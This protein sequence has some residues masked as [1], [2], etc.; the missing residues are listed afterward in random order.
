MKRY[1]V[2]IVAVSTALPT[3]AP[4]VPVFADEEDETVTADGGIGGEDNEKAEMADDKSSATDES[5]KANEADES[6][7]DETD[8][9][10]DET[11]G[12][13]ETSKNDKA[14]KDNENDILADAGLEDNEQHKS[15]QPDEIVKEEGI[16]EDAKLEDGAEEKE[17]LIDNLD[18]P[19]KA[20]T[21]YPK[22]GSAEYVAWLVEASEEDIKAW[23]D[24]AVLYLNADKAT[25]SNAEKADKNILSFD[26]DAFWAWVYED[27]AEMKDGEW[28][29][30]MDAI[31]SWMVDAGYKDARAF[32][33]EFFMSSDILLSLAEYPEFGTTE[34]FAWL[35]EANEDQV[36]RWYEINKKGEEG[37]TKDQLAS[38]A[39]EFDSDAFWEW[40]QENCATMIDEEKGIFS[41]KYD[42]IYDWA[43]HVPFKT[44]YQFLQFLM[45]N[46]QT[47]TFASIGRLWPNNYG[48]TGDLYS[49]GRGTKENPYIIDS[50][51]DLRLLAATIAQNPSKY[52]NND[53]Y[54]LIENGT[55]DLNGSWIPIGGALN[56]GGN[57]TAFMGH[58]A[59]EDRV[60]IEN[61]G[62]KS[63]T[64]IGI[65][66]DIV[67]SVIDQS[68]VGFFAKLG[69]GSSVTGLRLQTDNNVAAL[70]CCP[71]ITLVACH[72]INRYNDM[73]TEKGKG[74]RTPVFREHRVLE[75][76]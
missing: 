58:L 33:D 22:F 69:A 31:L 72:R 12:T 75:P 49:D 23:Y 46:A 73:R 55:Y 2:A 18:L 74:S 51:A 27:A 14:D 16:K 43:C 57:P 34:F 76:S 28:F 10:T 45:V 8:S 59:C 36:R 47:A 5:S 40:F 63:N 15:A 20:F 66:P 50:V 11:D 54:Y 26:T 7:K 35:E 30:D 65:T 29:Y 68:H 53:V 19:A 70:L 52:N 3:V 64:A 25:S 17:D 13:N 67:N 48:S 6:G 42:V 37:A 56:P 39:L 38:Y 61:F 1:T 9:N 32:M 41:Y 71:I 60:V 62:F 21:D 24:A 44:A 4:A